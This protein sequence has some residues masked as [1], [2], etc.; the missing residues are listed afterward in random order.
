MGETSFSSQLTALKNSYA[1]YKVRS[2]KGV[3]G[4]GKGEGEGRQ[5]GKMGG[6][7]EAD[8]EGMRCC[9]RCICENVSIVFIRI[10]LN[11]TRECYKRVLK[12]EP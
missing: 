10:H 2:K 9:N 8:R 4:G 3:L 11:Q 12:R 7:K 6:G 1:I 5:V